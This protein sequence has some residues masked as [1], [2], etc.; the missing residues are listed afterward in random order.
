MIRA[1]LLVALFG[2]TIAAFNNP[3]GVDI[4]CGKAYRPTNASFE[5]GGW[6]EEPTA[7]STPRLDLRI[8]PRMSLYTAEEESG[9]FIID[10]GISRTHGEPF[11]FRSVV[12]LD[13]AQSCRVLLVDVL[14]EQAGVELRRS[15]PVNSTANEVVFELDGLEP[16]FEPYDILVTVSYPSGNQSKPVHTATT[17]VYRLPERADGGSITKIDSLYGG[18]LVQDYLS[19][20]SVWTPILPYSFYVSWGGWLEKSLDNVQKFKDQGYNILHLVPGGG[21]FGEAFNLTELNMF[22]DKCDEIGLWVMWDMRWTYQNLTS[23]EEQV[24]MF[25]SRKS[26]LLW[27]TG[28]EPDGHSDPLN[29]TKEAYDKIKSLDPWH[30]ISLCL[31]CYNFYYEEYS[32]GADIILS[33]VYPIAVNTSWSDQYDT[34]CNTTYG[35]CGCDDCHGNFEDISL[36]LDRFSQYQAWIGGGPKTYWGVPQAFGNDSFW[37]RS[38]TPEE[39]VIMNMLSINHNAKGIVMWTYPT[40]TEIVNIA[41]KLSRVLVSP[42]VTGFLLG[43]QTTPLQVEG[44]QRIDAAGW[45]IGNRMLVSILYLEYSALQSQVTVLLPEGRARSIPRTLWGS[46]DWSV[47]EGQLVKNSLSGLETDLLIIELQ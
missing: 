6:L 36:R 46:G 17:Q 3:P 37:K 21:T 45:R 14:I 27:Y 11:D 32:S 23:V 42:E 35:C 5:P 30:P 33:D 1:A 22:L 31:N 19:D 39:E 10:A 40:N 12:L 15:V 43:A 9:S 34:A 18:L 29:A 41:S 2:Q 26:M 16:R 38:P 25:K 28:D 8:R 47:H 4:W 7:S 20:S 44:Q 24:N 13:S